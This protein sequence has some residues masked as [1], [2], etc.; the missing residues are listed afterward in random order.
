MD[1]YGEIVVYIDLRGGEYH[2]GETCEAH[3]WRR[4]LYGGE[5]LAHPDSP[6]LG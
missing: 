5:V 4:D 1:C 2:G 6:P 3:Y